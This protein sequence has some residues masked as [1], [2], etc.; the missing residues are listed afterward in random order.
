MTRKVYF[1]VFIAALAVLWA[2]LAIAPV[3]RSDW[4]LE[5]VLLFVEVA[6]LVTCRVSPSRRLP[7]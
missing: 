3:D 6:V 2:A 1:T 4:L 7:A 5:N